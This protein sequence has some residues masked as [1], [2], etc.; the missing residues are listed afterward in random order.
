[1]RKNE[2]T[3]LELTFSKHTKRWILKVDKTTYT[4]CQKCRNKVLTAYFC[5]EQHKIICPEC[6]ELYKWDC[7]IALTQ[8]VGLEHCDYYVTVEFN[9]N[10]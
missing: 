3:G 1:M 9:K 5:R 2:N 6:Y 4:G 7:G 10:D 8:Y